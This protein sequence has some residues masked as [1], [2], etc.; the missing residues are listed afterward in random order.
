MDGFKKN[1]VLSK[2][3]A[4]GHLKDVLE[5]ACAEVEAWS[6]QGPELRRAGIVRLGELLEQAMEFS[7]GNPAGAKPEKPRAVAS[8]TTGSRNF[9][10]SNDFD[11]DLMNEFIVE[12]MELAIMAESA[13]LDWE[14]NP[15]DQELLNTIFR[16]FHTI[17]GTSAFLNLDCVKDLAHHVESMLSRVRD[18][19]DDFTRGHADLALKSLD[20]I[21][22]ILERM[23]SSAPGRQIELPLGH[24]ELHE[25]LRNFSSGT[26]DQKVNYQSAEPVN[27]RRVK[28]R[29]FHKDV[30]AFAYQSLAAGQAQDQV[31]ESSV[32][33]NIDRLDKLLDTV[34]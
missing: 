15:D 33:V 28:E 2:G 24:E 32:R 8:E 27:E 20:L 9:T 5:Q 30:E 21:K 29:R 11:S 31:A 12:N 25:E 34:G 14:K 16:G 23:K 19:E 1:L 4:R 26:R 6:G 13:I 3:K 17:K 10:M 18:G 22:I 7:E